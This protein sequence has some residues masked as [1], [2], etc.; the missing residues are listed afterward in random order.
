M[1]G[2]QDHPQSGPDLP[3]NTLF[4]RFFIIF[5]LFVIPGSIPVIAYSR[6]REKGLTRALTLFITILTLIILFVVTGLTWAH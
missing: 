6:A 2:N 5:S 3:K 1:G 4:K